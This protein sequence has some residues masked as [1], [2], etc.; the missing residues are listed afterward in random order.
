MV[1]SSGD[2]AALVPAVR[3]IA[4]D[5]DPN[6]ALYEITTMD[7]IRGER[8]EQDRLGAVVT[9]FFAAAGLFLSAL[10]L[11]GVL[12]FAV[13]Q[14]TREIGVRLALGASRRDVMRLV[15]G[16]GV[17]LTAIGL[18]IGTA[19]AWIAAR[20]YGSILGDPQLDPRIIAA[21]AVMLLLAA[22][23]RRC[24]ARRAVR[25]DPLVALRAE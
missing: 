18:V 6:L 24:P 7:A 11:Y 15:V 8:L 20:V 9:S 5:L 4:K 10:G 3:T 19:A 17:R 16:R 12:T 2:P 14:D 25:M 13:A 23:W 1:R 22:C 21:G